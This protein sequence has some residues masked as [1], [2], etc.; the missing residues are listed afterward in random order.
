[1]TTTVST[2]TLFWTNNSWK[3]SAPNSA[4]DQLVVV[5]RDTDNDLNAANSFKCS[6]LIVEPNAHL[7]LIKG[8]TITVVNEVRVMNLGK[9]TI[10]TGC[11]LQSTGP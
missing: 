9:V 4:T 11:T 6:K 3:P 10:D 8:T 5:I 7:H 2:D 1:M